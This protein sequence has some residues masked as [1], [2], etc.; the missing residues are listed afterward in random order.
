MRDRKGR[1]EHGFPVLS[2][3]SNPGCGA[4][5]D[6]NVS[7]CPVKPEQKAPL[8]TP[9]PEG[10]SPE[11]PGPGTQWVLVTTGRPVPFVPF[12]RGS[13]APGGEGRRQG[14]RTA[15]TTEMRTQAEGPRRDRH[16]EHPALLFPFSLRS[17]P[18]FQTSRVP[19]RPGAAS[20]VPPPPLRVPYRPQGG[21]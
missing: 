1:E 16:A 12:R 19:R 5:Q 8:P 9:V 7:S 10:S 15:V 6:S 2:L 4:G 21:P 11:G 13:P 20:A 14:R 17:P 18:G 3:V